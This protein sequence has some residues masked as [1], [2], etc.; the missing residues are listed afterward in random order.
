MK[1]TPLIVLVILV[2][3]SVVT[4]GILL[5]NTPKRFSPTNELVG[6][7]LI[8]G[9]TSDQLD[10][11]HIADADH[12]VTLDKKKDKWVVA[13]RSD[14][15]VDNPR[16]IER[17]VA[18]L[19]G[20][21]VGLEIPAAERHYA[22]MGL[23][24]PDRT[25]AAEEYKEMRKA[26]GDKYPDEPIGLLITLKDEQD[27]VLTSVIVG[28]EFGG[29]PEQP[30]RGLVLRALTGNTGVWKVVGT[31]NRRT[32]QLGG[33]DVRRGPI[34]DPTSWLDYDFIEVEKLKELTLRAPNDEDFEPWTLTRKS[35]DDDLTTDDLAED[36]EMNTSNVSPLKTLFSSLRFE[37]VI[38]PEEAREK[39]DTENARQAIIT[40]FD[41]FTYTIDLHP[42]KEKTGENDDGEDDSP[43]TST[44]NYIATIKVDADFKEAREKAPDETAEQTKAKDQ[45]HEVQLENLK[46]KLR[47]EQA[48]QGRYY[49]LA[50]Y[51]LSNLLRERSE[52]VQPKSEDE[53]EGEDAEPPAGTGEPAAGP[54]SPPLIPP[55]TPPHE[56]AP[57][58]R[59]E[60]VT[61]PIAV[62][63]IPEEP[64]DE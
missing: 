34:A 25:E 21:Q 19:L 38:P 59:V 40:T 15:P 63:P 2:V 9:L 23:L 27:E 60:A 54:V 52:L 50:R 35:V 20:L 56:T 8:T 5:T 58:N 53:D 45:A 12:E 49:E 62:P 30:L 61:P 10:E 29:D 17:L 6:Q 36:M 4:A 26:R 51:T 13:N 48:Y 46:D 32:G 64:E 11:I 55:G 41:G 31:I 18:S 43:S 1:K 44:S 39:M 37:D 57:E 47:R 22:E 3:I 16:E 7:K 14:Y 42:I 24:H 28:E 33:S